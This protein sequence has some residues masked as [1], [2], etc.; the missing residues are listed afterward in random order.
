MILFFMTYAVRFR[1]Y[2][3]A[4]CIASAGRV[5]PVCGGW[6]ARPKAVARPD[7]QLPHVLSLIE[8]DQQARSLDSRDLFPGPIRDC[9]FQ[10][11]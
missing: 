9:A 10:S 5:S 8:S 11:P 7:D 2:A 3:K 4:A 1:E 6:N